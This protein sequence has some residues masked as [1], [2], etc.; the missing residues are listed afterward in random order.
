MVNLL[1]KLCHLVSAGIL[2][3]RTRQRGKASCQAEMEQVHRDV[4]CKHLD[5]WQ[6]YLPQEVINS[7]KR[8]RGEAAVVSKT[9]RD[10]TAIKTPS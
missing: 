9:D 1:K 3:S 8:K 2:A 4:C 10:K 7:G 5:L 6:I